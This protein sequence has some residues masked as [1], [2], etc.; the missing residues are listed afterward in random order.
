MQIRTFAA[1]ESFVHEGDRPDSCCLVLDGY[2]YRYK[3]VPSGARQISAIH[4]PGDMPDLQSLH[5]EVMD[6]SLRALTRAEMAFIPHTAVRETVR[7]F[8]TLGDALW[9]LTL[10]DASMFREWLTGIGR[11]SART[12]VAHLLCE[13]YVRLSAVGLTRDSGY[14]MP[15]TQSVLADALGLST[16]HINRVLQ[17]LRRARLI[18][19]EGRFLRILDWRGLAEAG[20]FDAAYLHLEL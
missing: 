10:V 20:E 14:D 2:V 17:D 3:L 16:V 19:S 12:R 13:L 18:A 1:D 5:I 8:P 11:R 9:R 4:I 7:L 15:L 6:H